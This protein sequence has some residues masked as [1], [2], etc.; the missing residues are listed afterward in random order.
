MLNFELI[1]AIVAAATPLLWAGLGLLVN[2]KAGVLN[3]GA[4]GMFLMGALLA[5]IVTQQTQNHYLGILAG[6]CAGLL[7][8]AL[9]AILSLYLG[10]QQ[11]ACGLALAIF[12]AG[13]SAFWGQRWVGLSS[14]L[15]PLSLRLGF[16]IVALLLAFAMHFMLRGS[17]AGLLLRALG[18]APVSAFALGMPVRRWQAYA[19]LFGGACVGLAGAY[20][21]LVYTPMWVEGMSAGRGWIALALTTFASW[22]PLRVLSGALLLGAVSILQFQLQVH[23]VNIPSQFLAM[24]P[25]LAA[26]LV[27]VLISGRREWLLQN[28]PAALG[29]DFNPQSK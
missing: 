22:R 14:P 16:P 20:L 12:A 8:A 7:A 2:E 3:L 26:I 4:E 5:F 1:A 25:Y 19:V 9:F 6:L 28:K 21:A 29:Q 11:L 24:L 13:L 18:E 10:A 17:R 23:G 27:L 15:A